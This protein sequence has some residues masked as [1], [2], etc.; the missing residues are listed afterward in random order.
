VLT[1]ALSLQTRH[2]DSLK[3]RVSFV[4]TYLSGLNPSSDQD[5]FIDH[6][7]RPFTSPADWG[8]EAC[9]THYDTPEVVVE[10]APK[11]V[12]QNRL[13]NAQRK[14]AEVGGL[15][16]AKREFADVLSSC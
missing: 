9:P 15:I 6:N 11:V 14:L 5:L 8:F 1:N 2:L 16:T 3:S 13:L 4:S 12:L 10:Q 7:I